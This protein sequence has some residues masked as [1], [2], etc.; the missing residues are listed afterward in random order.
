MQ[1]SLLHVLVII[2]IV[3]VIVVVAAVVCITWFAEI[4]IFFLSLFLLFFPKFFLSFLNLLQKSLMHEGAKLLKVI[5]RSDVVRK[6]RWGKNISFRAWK[7]TK[8][9][10]TFFYHRSNIKRTEGNNLTFVCLR[11]TNLWWNAENI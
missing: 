7:K 6:R 1:H 8:L 3:V 2:I 10:M 4:L 9:K 5:I 11:M